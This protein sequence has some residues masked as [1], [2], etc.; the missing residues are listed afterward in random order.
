M[1]DEIIDDLE[2]IG[3]EM[4]PHTGMT[5][6]R[7][8]MGCHMRVQDSLVNAIMRVVERRWRERTKVKE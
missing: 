3:W 4:D 8:T 6:Y 7:T 2:K 1:L 5:F